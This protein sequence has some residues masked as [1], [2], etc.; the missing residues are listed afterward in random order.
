MKKRVGDRITVM[1][2]YN[3]RLTV[4]DAIER[5]RM[6]EDEGL[7]WIE[8]PI[9]HDDYAG[10]ARIAAALRTPVQIGENL[11]NTFELIKALDA[12]AMRG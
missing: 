4:N 1:C 5:G 12:R 11:L 6:L 7:A 9:R 3:Q 2:D 8:E 10:C